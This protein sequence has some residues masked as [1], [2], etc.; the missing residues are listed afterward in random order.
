MAAHM[1]NARAAALANKPEPIL[2][3]PVC[4]AV[5][6]PELCPLGL[7]FLCAGR[8][9]SETSEPEKGKK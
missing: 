3:C 9:Y 8:L 1:E 6:M 2:V 5:Q 7:C 4:G